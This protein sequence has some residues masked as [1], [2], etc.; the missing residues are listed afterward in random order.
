[1]SLAKKIRAPR[2]RTITLTRVELSRFQ[3]QLTRLDAPAPV[4]AVLDKTICQNLLDVLPY[5]P[6]EFVDLLFIDP[7]YNLSK[8]FNGRTFSQ[9]PLAEYEIWLDLWLGPLVKILK[10]TASI[11][12]CGDWQSAAAIQRV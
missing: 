3:A 6:V 12:I 2:N 4:E 10:P 7:P 1:M 9:R 8:S 11:Y 5:L